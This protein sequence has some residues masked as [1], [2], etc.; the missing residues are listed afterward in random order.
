MTT[1]LADHAARAAAVDPR[2]S[3]IV[4]APAGSG[5]TTL[6]VT[7]F[8]TLLS[9]AEVPEEVLAITFTRKAATEMRSRV[10]LA[11]ATGT[12]AAAD[13]ARTRNTNLGWRLI[14]NPSRLA[15]QTIDSFA[16]RLAQ[17]MPAAAGFNL[18]AALTERAAPLYDEAA[19]RLVDKLYSKDPVRPLLAKF[20]ADNDN[21]ANACQRLIASMLASRD[22]WIDAVAAVAA[23]RELTARE[24]TAGSESLL[25]ALKTALQEGSTSSEQSALEL[26]VDE[27]AASEPAAWRAVAARLTTKDGRFR[28]RFTKTQGFNDPE[29]RAAA[30]LLVDG[31]AAAGLE[32]VVADMAHLPDAEL[33]PD[34]VRRLG[35]A[36]AVLALAIVELSE[37]F[38]ATSR[39]DFTELLLSARRALGEAQQPTELALALDYQIKHLL[40]DE[41]QDTSSSQHQ[42]LT[43]LTGEWSPEDSN[44][45]F[46]VGDPM[47]SIYRFRDADVGRFLDAKRNGLANKPLSVITLESNF[48]SAPT[49]IEWCNRIFPLLMGSVDEPMSGRVAYAGARAV[50]DTEG[51]VRVERFADPNDEIESIARHLS[52]LTRRDPEASIGVLIR[53]RTHVPALLTRFRAHGLAWSGNGTRP[54][55]RRADRPRPSLAIGHAVRSDGPRRVDRRNAVADAGHT[56][57]NDR[58]HR[59]RCGFFCGHVRRARRRTR[60][61]FARRSC[62]GDCSA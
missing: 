46:A 36:C 57:D 47:Q 35:D 2:S 42:L 27:E 56:T 34:D 25:V 48:R 30:Q 43:Q 44:T 4:Q 55:G 40:V 7:R 29:S 16:L 14:D 18:R 13:A 32:P 23:N 21:D 19:A 62:G 10:V 28:A 49:L 61:A 39:A 17:R 20:I 52:D 50:Q 22:Q 3:A 31:L 60:P 15:I 8:L 41:F 58:P 37:L 54:I 26:L 1:I 59:H 12:D 51:D 5:K 45:F 24:F 11:L 33:S 38:R 9:L 6:L 53:S